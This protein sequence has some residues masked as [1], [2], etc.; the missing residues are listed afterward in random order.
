MS[1]YSREAE[2]RHSELVEAYLEGYA[3]GLNRPVALDGFNA[4]DHRITRAAD[5]CRMW[6]QDVHSVL[7]DV[8]TILFIWEMYWGERQRK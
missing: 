3:D 7:I 8:K 1:V 5:M 6:M 2:D 4:W